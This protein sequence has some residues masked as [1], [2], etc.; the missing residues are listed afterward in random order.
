[1]KRN[2]LQ[3]LGALLVLSV[4]PA[5]LVGQAAKVDEIHYPPL[6][7][8]KTPVPT[9]VELDNGMTVFLIEDHELPLI[10][11]VARIRT[12][13]VLEPAGKVGLAGLTG[14]VERTGGTK[15][16]TPE[17][18]NLF[19]ENRAANA[20]TSI[21]STFGSAFMNCLKKDFHE[22]FAVFADILREPAFD[23]DQLKIA[24]NQVVAG[25]SRQ[26][27]QPQSILFREYGQIIFGDDSPLQRDRTYETVANI[28]RDDLVQ[29]HSRYFHPNNIILGMVGDFDTDSALESIRAEFGDWQT[30]PA[31]S[32]PKLDPPTENK[33]GVYYVEKNDMTQSNIIIGHLGIT[34]DNPDYYPIEVL[35]EV[36]GGG[37]AA[38]LF[39]NVRSNKGLAYSVAGGIGGGWLYPGTFNMFMT[40]KTES[41]GEA[42]GALL[43]EARNL[44]AKP[45]TEE[46]LG[47][48]K[49]AIL[50]S[51]V[52]RADTRSEILGQQL[53]YAY[54]GYPLDWLS[55]YKK[56]IE[57]V[58]LGEVRAVPGKYIHPD[59]FAIL[60]VG[61]A[62]AEKQIEQFGAVTDVDI[63]IP[64]S[65]TETVAATAE[66]MA[67]GKAIL[68]KAIEGVGGA[69]KLSALKTLVVEMTTTLKMQG[70]S[71][72]LQ[73]TVKMDIPDRVRRD[74]STPMG[75]GTIVVTPDY[76][77]QQSDRGTVPLPGSAA[78]QARLEIQREFLVLLKKAASDDLHP[79]AAGSE[80]IDGMPVDL[81]Q[82]D[83]EGTPHTLAVERTSGHIVRL[84]YHGDF[85]GQPADIVQTFSDFREVDGYT[86]PFAA[87]S[88]ANGNEVGA[89]A[90]KSVAVNQTIDES[91]FAKPE[92]GG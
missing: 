69:E 71:L 2:L 46:E 41:T 80:E 18:L 17:E 78:K 9:R 91:A 7:D 55:R 24:K 22:V 52:F 68:S 21:G 83:L 70:N 65:K 57:D 38:R 1:M 92:A 84:S 72:D 85:R 26:N 62:D 49:S 31:A 79:V 25:I 66:S 14:T 4:M 27:D 45:P 59:R 60:V 16:M 51:F 3:I 40:T 13:S 8:F 15:T 87:S 53:T 61:P 34:N 58:T 35:N 11:V 77:F 90:I 56:G 75:S 67:K 30:G 32:L 37:F 12:G 20:S 73:Q 36:F 23:E 39:S 42:I 74:L 28:T 6:P 5:L 82:I 54:Y 50:N 88:S 29:W 48:A 10:N 33:A 86:F 63:T 81:V 44:T 43:E 89:V 64:E 19:L 76:A 47:K